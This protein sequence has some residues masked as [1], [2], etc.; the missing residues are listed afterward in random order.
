MKACSPFAA[1][2]VATLAGTLTSLSLSELE[3]SESEL[4]S[5]LDEL[6]LSASPTLTVSQV[7]EW[8]NS[9]LT[10]RMA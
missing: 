3:L 8:T 5:E 2:L 7:H 9:R 6:T 4:E 1:A 10:L